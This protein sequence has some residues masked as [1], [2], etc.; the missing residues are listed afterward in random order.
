MSCKGKCESHEKC[1]GTCMSPDQL[2]QL[3]K[4]IMGLMS[5]S[6]NHNH[7]TC[8]C[9]GC[10]WWVKTKAIFQNGRLYEMVSTWKEYSPEEFHRSLTRFILYKMDKQINKRKLIKL[11]TEEKKLPKAQ[12]EK[13]AEQMCQV[14]FMVFY[15][16]PPL[17]IMKEI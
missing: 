13:V 7:K 2:M 14:M 10:Y 8:N 4:K 17:G 3:R 6:E 16:P 5:K 11:L 15:K 12:A 1:E 9:E